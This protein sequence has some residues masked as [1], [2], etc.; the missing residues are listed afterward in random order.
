MTSSRGDGRRVEVVEAVHSRIG[1]TRFLAASRPF[2]RELMV[3]YLSMLDR[4]GVDVSSSTRSAMLNADLALSPTTGP[5]GVVGDGY[6]QLRL[7]FLALHSSELVDCRQAIKSLPWQGRSALLKEIK[8]ELTALKAVKTAGSRTDSPALRGARTAHQVS[9]WLLFALAGFSLAVGWYLDLPVTMAI[10]VAFFLLGF[11]VRRRSLAALVIAI[12]IL[13]MDGLLLLAARQWFG[14]LIR[15]WIIT[16]TAKGYNAIKQLIEA[17][18]RPLLDTSQR[19][20]SLVPHL[21]VMPEPDSASA[22][23]KAISSTLPGLAPRIPVD[24]GPVPFDPDDYVRRFL[25]AEYHVSPESGTPPENPDVGAP[26]A[27]VASTQRCSRCRAELAPGDEFCSECAEPVHGLRVP[28]MSP[29]S[30]LPGQGLTGSARDQAYGGAAYSAYVPAGASNEA[31]RP[32]H[33]PTSDQTASPAGQP[34]RFALQG[35]MPDSGGAASVSG[36]PRKV[37]S[38]RWIVWS[39]AGLAL[40]LLGGG[41]TWAIRATTAS[42]SGS[43]GSAVTTTPSAEPTRGPATHVAATIKVGKFPLA[44]SVNPATREVYVANFD[45]KSVSVVDP[46]KRKVI[47][48]IK[49]DGNPSAV[50]VDPTRERLYVS[51]GVLEVFDPTGEEL[52][53]VNT[54]GFPDALA[55]DSTT[56]KLYIGHWESANTVSICDTNSLDSASGEDAK[57]KVGKHVGA[58]AVDPGS[59]AVYLTNTETGTVTILDTTTNNVAATINLEA[60]SLGV[61]VDEAARRLYVSSIEGGTDQSDV[62]VID[63]E[64]REIIERI[65]LFAKNTGAGSVAVDPV[66]HVLYVSDSGS[67]RVWVIDTLTNEVI[68]QIAVGKDPRGLTVDP[69]T[70][71]VYVA[72]SSKNALLVLTP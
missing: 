22:G 32:D 19:I 1:L 70:G 24:P 60:P 50:L 12:S 42:T 30:V 18:S 9:Y 25:T 54:D 15:I 66:A 28:A 39:G 35:G 69:E 5:D 71:T 56:S 51:T 44:V 11:F 48:T 63:T 49:F 37:K 41:A 6:E 13:G 4:A 58:L 31:R 52:N 57:V 14:V 72:G 59:H 65:W 45:G 20:D 23:P 26:E 62:V 29:G 67:G 10:A 38:R 53:W 33:R 46:E 3:Q 2:T 47:N 68:D 61:A 7:R 16:T 34:A 17:D 27:G 21:D 64:S 40:I 8:D 55:L 43:P 36:S